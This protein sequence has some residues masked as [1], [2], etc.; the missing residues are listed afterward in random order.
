MRHATTLALAT[1]D[2]CELPRLCRLA[3]QNV[4]ADPY[5]DD[6]TVVATMDDGANV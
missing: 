1:G 6:K 3:H 5:S 4:L 2:K